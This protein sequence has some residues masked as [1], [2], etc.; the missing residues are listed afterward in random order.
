MLSRP[1]FFHRAWYEDR[2]HESD[3]LACPS[4]T[5]TLGR[6]PGFSGCYSTSGQF[7]QQFYRNDMRQSPSLR[8]QK[9]QC[10]L[11][12]PPLRVP[13]AGSTVWAGPRSFGTERPPSDVRQGTNA[14]GVSSSGTPHLCAQTC[15]P[16][17]TSSCFSPFDK[18]GQR[19]SY[20]LSQLDVEELIDY[21]DGACTWG[22][23]GDPKPAVAR[24]RL[25]RS[26]HALLSVSSQ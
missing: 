20:G 2:H 10:V 6:D 16:P 7:M 9:E 26:V 14:S 18:M 23:V 1:H 19:M 12:L 21:C 15:L 3:S 4:G 22:G 5:P 13:L 11:L 8:L 17:T 24:S 25:S